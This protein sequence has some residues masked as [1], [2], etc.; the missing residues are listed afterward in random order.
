MKPLS[1]PCR[2][3]VAQFHDDNDKFSGEHVSLPTAAYVWKIH[4]VI[5]IAFEK[6]R[7]RSVSMWMCVWMFVRLRV[8][9]HC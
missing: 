6:F 7:S 8:D 4:F 5:V 9:M 2:A 1:F 3:T